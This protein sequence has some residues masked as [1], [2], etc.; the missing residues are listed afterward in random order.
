[1]YHF[2]KSENILAL[3]DTS[4]FAIQGHSFETKALLEKIKSGYP[5][6]KNF[7]KDRKQFEIKVDAFEW[8]ADRLYDEEEAEF[9][10]NVRLYE[11]IHHP[12]FDEKR[13]TLWL[14]AVKPL[15]FDGHLNEN[16]EDFNRYLR[17]RV[18][19][20]PPALIRVEYDYH[21]LALMERGYYRGVIDQVLHNRL[22]STQL[23]GTSLGIDVQRIFKRNI[24]LTKLIDLLDA[25]Y[26]NREADHLYF[27]CRN[28]FFDAIKN[29]W[30]QFRDRSFEEVWSNTQTPAIQM[31]KGGFIDLMIAVFRLAGV[32]RDKLEAFIKTSAK[33][34]FVFRNKD[35]HEAYSRMSEALR[36]GFPFGM[37][38]DSTKRQLK[39][40]QSLPH[41]PLVLHDRSNYFVFRKNEH[42]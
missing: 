27:S 3:P 37:P 36:T 33:L 34:F 11:S 19:L 10:F 17:S 41:E 7:I 26:K 20:L 15:L 16:M 9:F 8:F 21:F 29:T 30:S 35:I 2:L 23:S 28:L 38:G 22:E 25:A 12:D 32:A 42:N 14:Q 5:A 13:R 40:D 4:V 18:F 6:Y 24:P 39:T 31:L 1:M